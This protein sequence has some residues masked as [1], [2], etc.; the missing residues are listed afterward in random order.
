MSILSRLLI[1]IVIL[2][3]M[4]ALAIPM[5]AFDDE[6]PAGVSSEQAGRLKTEM[7]S[8]TKFWRLFKLQ[9]SE[10]RVTG[11]SPDDAEGVVIWRSAFGVP[12]GRSAYADYSSHFDFSLARTFVLWS[13]TFLLEAA[14]LALTARSFNRTSEA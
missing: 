1:A 7:S 2:I 14:M 13:G 10:I 12:V 5:L 8:G 6:R 11:P 4:L 3:S 9:V